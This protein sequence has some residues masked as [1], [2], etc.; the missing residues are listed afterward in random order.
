M[1]N[2]LFPLQR[3][4]A[5]GGV[6]L[7]LPGTVAEQHTRPGIEADPLRALVATEQISVRLNAALD[8]VEVRFAAAED[9]QPFTLEIPTLE[10]D[11]ARDVDDG[12]W[13]RD[14]NGP[15]WRT[16]HTTLR[17]EALGPRTV[18]LHWQVRDAR[19]HALVLRLR[20]NSRYFG[21]GERFHALNQKG[22][23]LPMVS[24]D[25]PEDKGVVS[26]KPVPWIMSTRGYG[27]WVD[28]DTCGPFDLNASEREHVLIHDRAAV[29]RVVL[30][31]GPA[32]AVLL[33]EFTRLTGRPPIPPA[34]AFAPWKSRNVHRNRREVLDDAELARRHDLPGSVIVID[35]P[36]E[37][38]YN[39]FTINPRQF[40]EHEAMF[41]RLRELGF[42]T[43]LWLTAFVN[44]ENVIDME[45]IERGPTRGFA[46]GAARGYFVR[47]ADGT[48]MIAEWWKG[49]GALLD[50]TNADA[51]AWWRA[52]LAPTLAWGVRAFK[53]DGGEGNFIA[54]DAV[55]ANGATGR[56]M[57]ARYAERYNAAMYD[58]VREATGGDG[59]L[60]SRSG[61]AGM[62]QYP[63]CWAGDNDA[64][65]SFDNGLPTAIL[66]G[67]TAALSGIVYWGSDIAGYSGTPTKELFIRWAQF[68]AF[69]PLMMIHMTSNLG[70][71]DFDAETLDIYRAFAKLHT[72]LYPY[73]RCCA[74][75]AATTGLPI[76]RPMALAFPDDPTAAEQRFQYLFGDELLVA[77]MF[78][79][80]AHRAVYLPAGDW[81]DYWDRGVRSGPA[82]VEVHAP[83]ARMPLFVRG[84]AVIPML[85]A[86]VD[87][88]IEPGAELSA[89]VVTWDGSLIVQAWPGPGAAR[90]VE[91]SGLPGGDGVRIRTTAAAA[92]DSSREVTIEHGGRA[93]RLH[94]VHGG[95]AARLHIVHGDPREVTRNGLACEATNDSAARAMVVELPAAESRSVVR[96]RE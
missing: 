7:M 86:D 48:P 45:G 30:I 3:A 64:S 38:G 33:A 59:V 23:I 53:C 81:V 94:I 84:G 62:Q 70:A 4:F 67:Q 43:C 66:A 25:R 16:R 83:L 10:I 73:L 60:L 27:F 17:A 24:I 41:A 50:F 91:L 22:C 69:S 19:P 52:K 20:D 12:G 58:F 56:E 5:I 77:P 63:F 49:R 14:A 78:Q 21:G 95:R 29:L 13:Q 32:P 28:S 15:F 65:F 18:A 8:R 26:Y 85:P 96:W 42:H 2:R 61:F 47:N 9:R 76:I 74:G 6:V 90:S 46:E 72:R 11:G 68:G 89:D 40:P 34:W 35:S 93:A 54:P 88:L 55:F 36:W 39:D 82:W 31:A 1:M 75:Q 80:G 92:A 79:P 57:R 37:T 44:T 71:W 87:T 51:V